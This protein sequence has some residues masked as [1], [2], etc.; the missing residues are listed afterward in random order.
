MTTNTRVVVAIAL[1]GLAACTTRHPAPVVDRVP[2]GAENTGPRPA[3]K[4]APAKPS[5]SA[6][7]HDGTF[8]TVKRGDTLFGIALDHG[9]DYRELAQWNRL[10]NP[11][12]IQVGQVL[13][14][15]PPDEPA[16][17]VGRTRVIARVESRP[18]DPA[19]A[20]QRDP[21]PVTTQPAPPPPPAAQPTAP[22]ASGAPLATEFIWPIKGK[23]LTGFA[24]PRQK[25]IDIEG[26]LGDPV[27]AAAPGRVTYIGSGIPGL[28]KLVVIKHEGGFITVYAHNKEILVKEQQAVTRGQK[29]AEVGNT[30]AD[31]PKLHFQ[32]RKG[33]SAVDPLRYLP[34]L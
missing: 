27:A 22:A 3:A 26:K 19:G 8:Y 23:V 30:D 33:A 31:R 18:L 20:P 24:E 7:L 4:S 2:I 16:V 21:G 10:E 28:G 32:I 11:S 34:R 17:Q 15:K 29:I 25:G 1:A 6:A 14:V 12:K 13:R 9:A 5:S